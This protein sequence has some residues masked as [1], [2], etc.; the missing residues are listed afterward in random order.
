MAL[1]PP[2]AREQDT[3]QWKALGAEVTFSKED[4]AQTVLREIGDPTRSPVCSN[5]S[6]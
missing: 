2:A 5:A 1:V 4:E 6:S 3:I